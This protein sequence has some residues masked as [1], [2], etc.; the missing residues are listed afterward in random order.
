MYSEDFKKNAITNFF[1]GEAIYGVLNVTAS[2]V[3]DN[4]LTSLDKFA[5]A[6]GGVTIR[7][8]FPTLDKEV[9][10]RIKLAS[11]K[12]KNNR[13]LFTIMPEKA[14]LIDK[15]Y[16]EVLKVFNQQKGKVLNMTVRVGQKG[17]TAWWEND[18]T[19]DL[20][21]GLGIWEGWYTKSAPTSFTSKSTFYNVCSHGSNMLADLIANEITV[22]TFTNDSIKFSVEGSSYFAK[23]FQAT[24]T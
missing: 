16:M 5:G 7:I 13:F 24:I 8:Y 23:K 2:A 17:T 20:T 22:Q 19:V 15:D 18:L 6:E 3:N 4:D 9:Y 21:K 1:G 10:W 11:G 14:E 12:I